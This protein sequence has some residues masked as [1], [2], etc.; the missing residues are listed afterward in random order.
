MSVNSFDSHY[1]LVELVQL[2]SFYRR[3]VTC[4]RLAG[5]RP[6]HVAFVVLLLNSCHLSAMS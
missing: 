1:D 3:Q 2:S 4:L 6:R 5:F